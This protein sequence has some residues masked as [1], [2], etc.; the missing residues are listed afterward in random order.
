MTFI[1]SASGTYGFESTC[2]MFWNVFGNRS[3]PPFSLPDRLFA[4]NRL[5]SLARSSAFAKLDIC[6]MKRIAAALLTPSVMP[7]SWMSMSFI[8]GISAPFFS[9]KKSSLYWNLVRS[10]TCHTGIC[11]NW[12]SLNFM[13]IHG[14]PPLSTIFVR[15]GR[16]GYSSV[17]LPN[18]SNTGAMMQPLL[19][20]RI[21]LTRYRNW[22]H[23]W[24]PFGRVRRLDSASAPC[25]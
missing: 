12:P 18:L 6:A 3:M 21:V 24:N 10:P 5:C 22:L 23:V 19:Q 25:P 13:A 9:P 1:W 14:Y 16:T 11:T 2:L 7:C 17:T 20:S 4:T 15:S 8:V